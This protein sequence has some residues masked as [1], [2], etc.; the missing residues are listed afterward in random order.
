MG[1]FSVENTNIFYEINGN[2]NAKT[3]IAFFNG[4]MASTASWDYIWP[5]FENDDF[6][7]VRHD[8]R[9]QLKSDKPK[10]PY[11]FEIHANDAKQLFDH[12]DIEKIHIIG[13]SYGG[14]VAMKFAILYPEMTKSIS[15]IDSVSELDEVLKG[16]IDN[17]MILAD[18]YDG[19]KFFLG[20]AP[21]IY[22]NSFYTNKKEMLIS[23]AKA[24]AS[25]DKSY[26]EGQKTL[27]QTFKEDVYMTD[28]LKS[29]KC[30]SLVICGQDD[31]LKRVKFS[32]L[33]AK[34]IPNSEFILIP[35]SGHVAILEKYNELNSMLYGFILKQNR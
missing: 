10:G 1:T 5:V 16:F 18:L 7:I 17:W 21:S 31:L 30:P 22:G 25:M 24:F 2:E 20:M 11:S 27:Y 9:G 35:D 23:R 34:E 14:E 28:E 13:T 3:A 29:I 33:I 19:E 8:F 4:V 26:F 6:M 15:I 32:Q 12:L